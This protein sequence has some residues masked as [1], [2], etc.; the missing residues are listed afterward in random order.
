MVKNAK[1]IITVTS[2]ITDQSQIT[3]TNILI[4]KNLNYCENYQNVIQRHEV[5][6]CYWENGVDKW[7]ATN[8]PSVKNMSA[9]CNTMKYVF[10]PQ[11]SWLKQQKFIFSH[12]WR[13]DVQD[14]GVSRF[15]FF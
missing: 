11:T 3:I 4:V 5:S 9:K 1:A 7:V 12:F 13:L 2:K 14:P 6:K 15:G 8:F 10:L